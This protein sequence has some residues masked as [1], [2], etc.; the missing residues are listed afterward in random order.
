MAGPE[1]NESEC[2]LCAAWPKTKDKLKESLN[3]K[4][5]DKNSD[6]DFSKERENPI[7]SQLW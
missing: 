2:G 3:G 1:S 6:S 5:E 4:Y 7:T